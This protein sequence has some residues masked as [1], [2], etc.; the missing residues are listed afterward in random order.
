MNGKR[1]KHYMIR[2]DIER[3]YSSTLK[4]PLKIQKLKIELIDFKQSVVWETIHEV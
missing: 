2:E 1:L 4:E 3:W